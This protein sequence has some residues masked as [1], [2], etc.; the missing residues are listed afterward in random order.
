MKIE[1][2]LSE[3][4]HRGIRLSLHQGGLRATGKTENLTGELKSGLSDLKFDLM[5]KLGAAMVPPLTLKEQLTQAINSSV[6]WSDLE[7]I[8]EQAQK[9]Y[10]GARLSVEDID[11]LAHAS[12]KRSRRV[13]EHR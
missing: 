5:A 2:L 10:E 13:P 7:V 6:Q 3:L 9:A 4:A 8:L 1:E 11:E 12:L